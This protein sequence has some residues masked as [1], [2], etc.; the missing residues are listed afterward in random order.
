MTAQSPEPPQWPW[1]DSLDALVAAP[2]H[3]QLLLEN[4]RVRVLDVRIAPGQNV[5]V[6]THKWPSIVYVHSTSDFIRRDGQ[7]KIIFDSRTASAAPSDSET[8][9]LP[10]LPPHSVENIGTSEIHLFTVELKE[11]DAG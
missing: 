3:H 7:G 8:Q 10:P 6:H 9:Y 4:D 11:P 1:P 5:P 2:K